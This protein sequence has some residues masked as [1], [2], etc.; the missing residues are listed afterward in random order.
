M[1]TVGEPG[2]HGATTTGTHGIGVSTPNAAD[3]ALATAGFA[4]LTHMPKRRIF[5]MG[6]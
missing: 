3:V 5:T 4:R 2:V 6:T 1:R